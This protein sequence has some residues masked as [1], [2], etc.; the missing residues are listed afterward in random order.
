[1]SSSPETLENLEIIER[2]IAGVR[3][4]L[5]Q[6][7]EPLGSRA[8]DRVA[9][10]VGSWTFLFS[11]LFVLCL[12]VSFQTLLPSLAFDRF[13]FVLMNLLLS[14]QAAF[15]APIL[16]M[17][18]NRTAAKDR[19]HAKKAYHSIDHMEELVKFLVQMDGEDQVPTSQDPS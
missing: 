4:Q 17:A 9:G 11:Q 16:M 18:Q 12:Y 10:I 14:F 8:A 7:P 3:E 13:P 5:G 6:P 19:R 2:M 15:T 1:M